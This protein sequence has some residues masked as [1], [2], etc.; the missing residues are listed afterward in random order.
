L[1]QRQEMEIV[2]VTHGSFRS[3]DDTA[4]IAAIVV[5]C[6]TSLPPMPLPLPL[7]L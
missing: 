6:V 2:V 4:L 3:L 5:S 7:N 1:Y